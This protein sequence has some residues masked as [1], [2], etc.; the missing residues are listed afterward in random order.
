MLLVVFGAG[1]SYDSDPRL[2]PAKEHRREDKWRPP[3]TDALFA[4]RDE[5][6]EFTTDFPRILPLVAQLGNVSPDQPL[7]AILS[8]LADEAADYPVRHSELTAVRYYLQRLIWECERYWH[9]ERKGVT[10]YLGLLDR[11]QRWRKGGANSALFVTF[12]YDRLFEYAASYYMSDAT[13]I[14]NN[15][16]T[17]L[18]AYVS[19]AAFPLVK[20]HGSIDWGYRV[21]TP[22]KVVEESNQHV[23]SIA[24][25]VIARFATLEIS[26]DIS[27]IADR[28]P[29][30]Q[31]GHAYIPALAVPLDKKSA[32]ACPPS[33]L[34]FLEARLPS[35]RSVL[36][37]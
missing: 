18:D 7:E 16:Y 31:D 35:V 9:P 22:L 34:D 15:E 20:V 26:A 36:G 27:K 33:H 8:R 14:Y 25:D 21:N 32:F 13:K 6:R 2:P 4:N 1:A 10:N 29:A 19:E 28:P 12:N 3:L 11:I 17:T 23:W 30:P 37:L 5:F 24:L